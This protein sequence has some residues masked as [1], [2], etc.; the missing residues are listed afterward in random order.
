MPI[1]TQGIVLRLRALVVKK[2]Q[3]T[4]YGGTNFHLDNNITA[5]INL[6][7]ILLHSQ[8]T[9]RQSNP[10]TECETFPPSKM[11][12]KDRMLKPRPPSRLMADSS[13][14]W[15][16]TDGEEEDRVIIPS[17]EQKKPKTVNVHHKQTSL[18]GEAVLVPLPEHLASINRIAVVPSFGQMRSSEWPSQGCQ[19]QDGNAIFRNNYEDRPISHPLDNFHETSF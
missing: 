12:V 7:T 13:K 11:T 3:A 15:P 19:V 1:E 8:F 6:G 14:S 10:K 17:M 16:V 4:C 2:L 9:I 18:P 5:N